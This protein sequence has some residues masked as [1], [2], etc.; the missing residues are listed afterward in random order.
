MQREPC[1]HGATAHPNLQCLPLPPA[2][3]CTSAQTF[4]PVLHI[5]SNAEPQRR[6]QK[7]TSDLVVEGMQPWLCLTPKDAAISVDQGVKVG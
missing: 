3:G 7:F 6:P 4:T 2:L 1:C 5:T